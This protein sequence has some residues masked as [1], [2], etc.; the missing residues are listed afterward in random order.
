VL[1][2]ASGNVSKVTRAERP[3]SP[4]RMRDEEKVLK[5]GAAHVSYINN[6]ADY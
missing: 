5:G 2:V 3:Q 6:T 4:N 1:V